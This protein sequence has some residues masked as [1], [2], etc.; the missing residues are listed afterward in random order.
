MISIGVGVRCT[1]ALG[2]DQIITI[3]NSEP[4]RMRI[5]ERYFMFYFGASFLATIISFTAMAEMLDQYGWR[6]DFGVPIVFIFIFVIIFFA[7]SPLYF[8]E[9]PKKG[10]F[11][12]VAQVV[13]ATFRN[14]KLP[15]PDPDASGCHL[16]GNDSI[17]TV[18]SDNLRYLRM[19]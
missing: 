6:V 9:K 14:R 16:L 12:R 5:I 1:V 17:I 18:P 2:A 15:F 13:V 10:L 19:A 11:T 8:K 3:R 4:Q 7:C